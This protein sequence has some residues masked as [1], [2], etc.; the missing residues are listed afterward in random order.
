MVGE[1]NSIKQVRRAKKKIKVRFSI[2]KIALKIL[3]ENKIREI[4]RTDV[5][6]KNKKFQ[7]KF[8][9]SKILQ[10]YV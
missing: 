8:N 3:L 7:I 2:N 10:E 4:N 6:A 5:K 9:F 1:G